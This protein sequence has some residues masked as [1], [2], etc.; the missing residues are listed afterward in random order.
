MKLVMIEWIDC[1]AGR[2]W[3]SIE[4]IRDGCE[5]VYCRS[6]GWLVSEKNGH[7]V[8]VPHLSGEKNGGIMIHGRGDL[9]IP[10]KAIQK[11]TVLK[12]Q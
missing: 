10:T 2:G 8:I 7:K 9:T 12:E 1:H 3:Q 11:M 4:D 6:V 5:P